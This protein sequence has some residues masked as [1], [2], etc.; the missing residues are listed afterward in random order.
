MAVTENTGGTQTATINTEHTLATIT[1]AGVFQLLVDL[2][3][4]VDGDELEL[5]IDIEVRTAG[6]PRTA[7]YATYAHEQGVDAQI[8]ISPPIPSVASADWI[9]TLKQTAGTGRTFTWA[10][11][12]YG[13]A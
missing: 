10:I 1:D 7:F 8:S 11:Y 9:A 2:E 4:M 13:N 12:E 3:P 5:R 6:T